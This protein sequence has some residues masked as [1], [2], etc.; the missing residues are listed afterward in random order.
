[1][2]ILICLG[3]H[4]N[5][6]RREK[7][8]KKVTY[9]LLTV[10]V[11]FSALNSM[12]NEETQ[13]DGLKISSPVFENNGYIPSKYTCDGRDINPSLLIENIPAKS[14]SLALIV[15]DPDAPRGTWVHW[16]LWNI[17]PKTKQI[18]ENSIPAGAKQGL[19]DFRKRTYGG[20]CPP[21]GTHR[22]FFKLYALD[23]M[24]NLGSDATKA[25]LEKAMKGHIIDQDQSVG[26]YKRR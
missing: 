13:R 14:K 25:D 6:G 9:L 2:D 24:L 16:V 17:D 23:T 12:G 21:S 5:K 4:L 10:S 20:P 7:M 1:V 18:K 3:Y 26:L 22:Y 8:V 19:N 11:V 15:D